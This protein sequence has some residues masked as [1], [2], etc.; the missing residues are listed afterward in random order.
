M[1]R[2][3][4]RPLTA[5]SPGNDMQSKRSPN[6]RARA[7]SQLLCSFSL[8]A[9]DELRIT[10]AELSSSMTKQKPALKDA[11]MSD[12]YSPD[13]KRSNHCLPVPVQKDQRNAI[14]PIGTSII[15]SCLSQALPAVNDTN[16][17]PSVTTDLRLLI[18]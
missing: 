5:S 7:G 3:I 14:A 18:S 17:V 15:M 8:R 16:G 10:L 4:A 2:V 11:I 6:A 1:V 9:L 12:K 13:L